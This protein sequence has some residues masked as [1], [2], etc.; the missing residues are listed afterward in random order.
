VQPKLDAH[1]RRIFQHALRS[2]NRAQA[3]F[4]VA[5]AFATNH[6][7]GIW[8]N[9]KDLDVFCEPADAATVLDVLAAAGFK[10]F[11]EE[12][13][14][15]G[16]A[17]FEGTMVDVI[18][19]GG[20][21]TNVVDAHWFEHAED[22]KVLGVDVK[23]APAQDIILSKAWV[24]G[25]ERYDG[26]DISHLILNKGESFDWD[27]LVTRFG[28]HWGLLLQYLVLFRFVYP[29]HRDIVPASLIQSL[30]ARIGT[31]EELRD[32]LSFR[33]TLLDRYAYLH[34]V[35]YEERPDPRDEVATRAGFPLADVMRRRQ[36][37]SDAFDKGLP[38]RPH[39]AAETVE[40]MER[41]VAADHGPD[42]EA[43]EAD[44]AV[45]QG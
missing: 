27:D 9:T 30:A 15:L 4:L 18:W 7:T 24:A 34:D 16:K 31:D 26:A 20:N 3:P 35:R 43:T 13:H 37:D 5:G 25:R 6:H 11:V 10:T 45:S 41:R 40:E 42:E 22:G 23:I 28:D 14:W 19:G 17:L 2:L 1:T 39:A 29:E 12:R 33:G 32:G 38:Y 8:R 21:W 36:L 44:A